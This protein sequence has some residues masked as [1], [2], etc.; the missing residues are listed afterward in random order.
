MQKV[1]ALAVVALLSVQ[2]GR[3]ACAGRVPPLPAGHRVQYSLQHADGSYKYG[4]DTGSGPHGGQQVAQVE[5]D[6]NNDVRGS[7]SG[8]P[9]SVQYTAGVGG[10]VPIIGGGQ[11]G[12]HTQ[13]GPGVGLQAQSIAGPS[14]G[15]YHHMPLIKIT[16]KGKNNNL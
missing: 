16:K 12:G 5:G 7:Y 6:A 13:P 11:P 3:E 9:V 10:Y 2:H 14:H 15:N 4:W 8:G 1:A